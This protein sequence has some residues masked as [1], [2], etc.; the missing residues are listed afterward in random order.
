MFVPLQELENLAAGTW[1]VN[2]L[3]VYQKHR[4]KGY[5]AR[6]LSLADQTASNLGLARLSIIVSDANG[7]A[8]RLYERCG[9]RLVASRPMVKE[10]WISDGENWLL[11]TKP[12]QQ[13]REPCLT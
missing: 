11:L 9:F 13:R 3:A 4:G 7:G 6:L 1:Y 8:R 10:D 12:V 5:G 2:V